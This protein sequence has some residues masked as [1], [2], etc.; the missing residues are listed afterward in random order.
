[1]VFNPRFNFQQSLPLVSVFYIF[2]VDAEQEWEQHEVKN[3]DALVVELELL[4]RVEVF[5]HFGV[6][7]A[8]KRQANF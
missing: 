2:V 6:L 3:P 1:M 8:V 7:K 4:G 5:H